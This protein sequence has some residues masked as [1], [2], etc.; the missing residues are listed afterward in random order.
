MEKEPD[1]QWNEEVW[2]TGLVLLIVWS[3]VNWPSLICPFLSGS[4]NNNE[5]WRGLHD[6]NGI[7]YTKSK[8]PNLFLH[9]HKCHCHTASF[10]A[11]K[12]KELPRLFFSFTSS[13]TLCIW[14]YYWNVTGSMYFSS[15]SLSRLNNLHFSFGSLKYILNSFS[16]FAIALPQ[17]ILHTALRVNFWNLNTLMPFFSW[18]AP[19]SSIHF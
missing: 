3:L 16:I 2:W 9:L 14:L 7:A 10:P 8:S 18:N 6:L 1:L 4:D 19:T 12:C 13:T 17:L 15:L 11:Q 5:T